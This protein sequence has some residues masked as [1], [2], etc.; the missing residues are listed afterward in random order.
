MNTQL[1]IN[2]VELAAERMTQ[3]VQII[4][5]DAMYGS[6]RDR[7]KLIYILKVFKYT[8]NLITNLTFSNVARSIISVGF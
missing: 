7:I 6:S 5:N 2:C 1:T 4:T 3:Q 8:K